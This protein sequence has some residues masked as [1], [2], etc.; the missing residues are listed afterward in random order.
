MS[1]TA[2]KAEVK[3]ALKGYD[4]DNAVVYH[5]G[6]ATNVT[7]S[8]VNGKKVTTIAGCDALD[9]A[10]YTGNGILVEV[11]AD[12]TD[13]ERVVVIDSYVGK[14]TKV[15]KTDE[16]ITIT[17][18]DED[19]KTITTA[20]GYDV[21]AKDEYVMVSPVYKYNN[22][23][24]L[25]FDMDSADDAVVVAAKK[26]SGKVTAATSSK[27]ELDGESYKAAEIN[28]YSAPELKDEVNVYLDAYGFVVYCDEIAAKDFVYV[29]T[30]YNKAGAWGDQSTDKYVQAVTIDGTEINYV[31][32]K[33]SKVQNPSAGQLYS[34]SITGGKIKLTAA[35]VATSSKEAYVTYVT[36]QAIGTKTNSLGG[37]RYFTDETVFVSVSGTKG[38]LQVTVGTGKQ[39]VEDDEADY[40]IIAT[41]EKKSNATGDIAVV[42]V[43]SS[44]TSDSVSGL[45]LA[46]DDDRVGIQDLNDV[47][48]DTYEVYIDGEKQTIPVDDAKGGMVKGVLYTASKN[49]DGAYKLVPRDTNVVCNTVVTNVY[50]KWL[51]V[52]DLRDALD[53]TD[54]EFVDL[55]G[56]GI[57]SNSALK[58]LVGIGGARVKVSVVYTSDGDATWVYVTYAEMGF[59][60]NG[61]TYTVT[62]AVADDFNSI[63]YKES[64]VT[65]TVKAMSFR[66]SEFKS[67]KVS[68]IDGFTFDGVL[69][70]EDPY[71][72]FEAAPAEAVLI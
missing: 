69:T 56:N 24:V 8:T 35:D 49:S 42:F 13:V 16:T 23:N 20:E 32:H 72:P 1:S 7:E 29:V 58:D 33:D 38:D 53:T 30:T 9:V 11:Y 5:N 4:L 54:A 68:T 48:Y 62:N 19:L 57:D 2:G 47:E 18:V 28:S 51:N 6:Q 61:N 59:E 27:V 39:L 52:A 67:V 17:F 21:F 31:I 12:G 40:A 50:S 55:T 66:A 43:N 41:A 25:V 63:S 34:Y 22:N 60:K 70:S 44:M 65:R 36:D 14:V 10:E 45:I 71:I 64:G 46:S 3:K 37:Y 26:E 15:N